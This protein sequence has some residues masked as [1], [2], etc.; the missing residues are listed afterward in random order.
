M[1][2]PAVQ[3]GYF[4]LPIAIVSK[5]NIEQQL[6]SMFGEIDGKTDRLLGFFTSKQWPAAIILLHLWKNWWACKYYLMVLNWR[7][8]GLHRF[9]LIIFKI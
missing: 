6:L 3:T 9:C 1:V 4:S 7:N 5:N 8:G 2:L